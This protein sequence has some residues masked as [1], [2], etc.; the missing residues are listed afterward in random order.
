MNFYAL[1]EGKLKL[2]HNL[3]PFNLPLCLNFGLVFE[4]TRKADTVVTG[5]YTAMPSYLLPAMYNQAYS[6]ECTI[7]TALSSACPV[8]SDLII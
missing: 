6:R 8:S 7:F 4:K 1:R 5:A 3:S 2:K